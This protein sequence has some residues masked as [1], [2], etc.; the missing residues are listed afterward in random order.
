MIDK[1]EFFLKNYLSKQK[2]E[3]SFNNQIIKI[4]TFKDKYEEYK[5]IKDRLSTCSEFTVLT[6][7]ENQDKDELLNLALDI[8]NLLS[9]ALGQRI[10][11]DKQSYWINETQTI[12]NKEMNE[13]NNLGVQIIPDSEIENFLNKTLPKWSEFTKEEKTDYFIVIDYLNQTR[14]DF[15]EDRILRTMQ[16]W[17]CSA[18]YWTNSVELSEDLKELEKRISKTYKDWKKEIN[19]NDINGEIGSNLKIALN[20]EKLISRL[21][22]FI[23]D[24]NFNKQTINLNLREL[25]KMRDLVVHEGKIETSGEQAIDILESGIKALQ[26]II[27]KRLGYDGLVIDSENKWTVL[28]KIEK[29]FK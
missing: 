28:N 9:I 3:L 1:G 16:A 8:K 25:K 19:Y 26:I 4:E 24:C 2:V 11:F 22:K 15:I 5:K 27:L 18:N 7:T 14:K 10:I 17:E 29:Y 23:L 21:D 20:Q 6:I 13:S 12:V